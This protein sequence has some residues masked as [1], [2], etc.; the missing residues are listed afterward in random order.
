MTIKFHSRRLAQLGH[1]L[2]RLGDL[3]A[4]AF[5]AG[6]PTVFAHLLAAEAELRGE[7]DAARSEAQ[8]TIK[9]ETRP[10]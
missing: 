9:Q 8:V 10:P 2:N 7:I 5:K 6:A 3:Q 4:A 1:V